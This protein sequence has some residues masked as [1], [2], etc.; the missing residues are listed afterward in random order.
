MINV[1]P[2]NYRLQNTIAPYGFFWRC[3]RY[4]GMGWHHFGSYAFPPS[5]R[6]YRFI[7]LKYIF[8]LEHTMLTWLN[9]LSLAVSGAFLFVCGVIFFHR[10]GF[11]KLQDVWDILELYSS[12]VKDSSNC[13]MSQTYFRGTD[14][15]SCVVN[16]YLGASTK[17]LHLP[18]WKCHISLP[19]TK[20]GH[21]VP[22]LPM[23]LFRQL[24]P[25]ILLPPI[26]RL[27]SSPPYS[28]G[29]PSS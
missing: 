15:R 4:G 22:P 5:W 24:A 14:Q 27:S 9:V 19:K 26:P 3:H 6:T 16:I 12:T 13:K 28:I 10:E 23:P 18:V 21:A 11:L 17:F 20:A 25:N 29:R 1:A 7:V 2:P 8:Y